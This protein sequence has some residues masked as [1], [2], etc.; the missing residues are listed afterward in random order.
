MYISWTYLCIFVCIFLK[1]IYVCS[2][3]IVIS[4]KA[5]FSAVKYV[6]LVLPHSWDLEDREWFGRHQSNFTK[7]DKKSRVTGNNSFPIRIVSCNPSKFTH[8][9]YHNN[10]RLLKKLC[11][12]IV[13]TILGF[14]WIILGFYWFVA[15]HFFGIW[16]FLFNFDNCDE[17]FCRSIVLEVFV[18]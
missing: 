12:K 7:P 15:S 5:F 14:C 18:Y 17:N 11:C 4:F 3:T 8:Y 13:M 6:A 16:E 10:L 2:R 1:Y 9:I